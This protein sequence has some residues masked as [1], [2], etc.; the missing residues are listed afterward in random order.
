MIFC[1]VLETSFFTMFTKHFKVITNHWQIRL[2]FSR[3]KY[4][5]QHFFFIW[6]QEHGTDECFSDKSPMRVEPWQKVHFDG[7]DSCLNLLPW[8]NMECKFKF[9]EMNHSYQSLLELIAFAYSWLFCLL[10]PLLS[11]GFSPCRI[12]HND[13]DSTH[14]ANQW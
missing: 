6:Q 13:C 3:K 7:I 9:S 5:S 11:N 12:F 14:V 4:C 1:S 2:R 8:L 10:Q